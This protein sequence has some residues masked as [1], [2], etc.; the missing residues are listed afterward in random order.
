MTTSSFGKTP[1]QLKPALLPPLNHRELR[2]KEARKAWLQELNV[3]FWGAL[4]RL[5]LQAAP[6]IGCLLVAGLFTE[7]ALLYVA[8]I[9]ALSLAGC[10]LAALVVTASWMPPRPTVASLWYEEELARL[11]HIQELQER[12]RKAVIVEST[13]S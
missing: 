4:Q 7:L 10:A 13:L 2:L 9:F 11:R 5:T 12:H 3:T 6:F 8:F 1:Q